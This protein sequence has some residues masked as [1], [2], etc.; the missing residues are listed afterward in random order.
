MNDASHAFVSGSV[1]FALGLT[2]LAGLATGL[3]SAL[4]FFARRTNTRLLAQSLAFSAGVMLYVSFIEILP[5]ASTDLAGHFSASAAGWLAN[6]GFFAGMLGMALI[7]YLVPSAENPHEL[8]AD[9]EL[10]ALKDGV[11]ADTAEAEGQ[12]RLW[13][14][15][16]L[17][18]AAIA[19]HNFPEG[20]ATYL[21]ALD[22]PQMGIGIAIAVALHNIP[23]GISVAVPI[24]FATGR[25]RRAFLLSLLS[26]L[27]EPLGGI[28]AAV[29]LNWLI[30]VEAT[31]LLFASVAGIMVY[32]SID[33]L[34]PTAHKYGHSHEVLACIAGG[35]AVM[36][37]SLL[38]L[39]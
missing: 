21:A 12:R 37:V 5:K 1:G 13:R 31:G 10:Q 9:A 14:I 8:R 19:I 20:M 30:P 7:D 23:E 3:G 28:V 33:E 16:F 26:G 38:I 22:D 24:F 39:R 18:A 11:A 36:A 4:A 2:L 34:L 29:A 15:G 25:R 17:T 27:A 6:A 32:I 35:M